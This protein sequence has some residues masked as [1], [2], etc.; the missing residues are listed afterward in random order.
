MSA[1][2]TRRASLLLACAAS[3]VIAGLV[4]LPATA[5]AD[6]I[7]APDPASAS[8]PA[9]PVPA[10]DP[11]SGAEPAPAADPASATDPAPDAA[12]APEP[13]A[14]DP[15][16]PADAIPVTDAA[17]AGEAATPTDVV[18]VDPAVTTPADVLADA[19][20]AP[21]VTL[22][23]EPADPAAAAAPAP[24]DPCYPAV[25]IDNGTILLA[26][27]PTGELNTSDG[28]GSKAG[29]GDAGLEFLPT[30]NDSTS[31][32]CLCEGWGV[33]DPATGVWGGANQ[34]DSPNGINLSVES[35]TWT[36][37]T[38]T[39]VVLVNDAEG[40][41]YFRVTHEYVPS[42][43]TPN[44]YQV[45]VTIEN[46]SGAP[47]AT[48]QYR[49]VMDWDIEPT[50]FN[51]F[52]TIDGGTATA[53]KFTSDDGFASSNP[54]SGPSQILFTGNAVDSGPA[55]HGALFDFSF[56]GLDVGGKLSFVIY[57]GGA[58]AETDAQ[59]ALAA[60]GAEAYSFGQT[61]TD[62]AGGTPNTF[63]FA[64]GKVGGSAIF[65]APEP[66]APAEVQPVVDVQPAAPIV[67][68]VASAPAL[69]ATGSDPA[70]TAALPWWSLA[71]VTGIIAGAALVVLRRRAVRAER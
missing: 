7:A 25:C 19:P 50:A 62:P 46:M 29:P 60:V 27:N 8:A 20:D 49:R 37:S 71:A 15:A 4:L 63:I 42:E 40:A 32:G 10:T 70:T 13:V 11:G 54:L 48:V 39:S 45:N 9:D 12:T 36:G 43:A 21:T 56:G 67:A 14:A 18:V 38:A 61:S 24:G 57:Y 47:I 35:F 52:V 69:A 33:A 31:P 2:S 68:E 16:A 34:D 53:L 28:T 26:V 6:E 51:E 66:P 41:P 64:F 59:A 23:A 44:L 3:A 5:Q 30:G 55:D 65:A 22:F 58:A 1:P 17:P